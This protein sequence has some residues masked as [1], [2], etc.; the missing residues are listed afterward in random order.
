MKFLFEW[1]FGRFLNYIFESR[2]DKLVKTSIK[3]TQFQTV[4]NRQMTAALQFDILRATIKNTGKSITINIENFT[5]TATID[6]LMNKADGHLESSYK[7]LNTISKHI[8]NKTALPD[9]F[10]DMIESIKSVQT[11]AINILDEINRH[12]ND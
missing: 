12:K 4:Q 3:T 5:R 8:D 2:T 11:K 1:L 7:M 6:A 10:K 9:N